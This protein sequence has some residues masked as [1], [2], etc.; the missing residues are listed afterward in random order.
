MTTRIRPRP[1]ASRWRVDFEVAVVGAGQAGLA[2]SHKLT[3]AGVA[4]VVL[5]R[6]RV[7][8]TWRGH[9]DSFCLVTP[10]WSVQ[11]P[12]YCYDGDD[13]DGFMPRDQ[14]VAYLQR[15]AARF[16]APVREGVEVTSLRP[17]DG[18]FIL[19]TSAGRLTARQVVVCTG[20]FQ[21][22]HRPAAAALPS[23]VLDVDVDDYRNPP[24]LPPG[25]VLIVGSGQSGCQIAEDLSLSAREV[26]MSCGRTSW[27]PRR[28]GEQDAFW[29]ML[30]TGFL[31]TPVSA[32]PSPAARLEGNR[33]ATGRGG[34]HD[35]HL[36]T[37]HRA[38]VTLLGHF[39]GMHGHRA[40]FAPD[41]AATIAWGDQQYARFAD[42]IRD[43]AV[44]RRMSPPHLPPPEPLGIDPPT[45]LDLRRFGAVVFASGFRPDYASWVD[46]PGAFDE[47]G[48]PIQHDGAS[49]LVEGL[50]FLGVHYLRKRKSSFLIGVG[51]D[52][53]IVAARIVA[54]LPP[55]ASHVPGSART[56]RVA[57]LA[58]EDHRH[59]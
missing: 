53:A 42:L 24:S 51:E 56:W 19:D 28:I 30:E 11:L 21:R 31:D 34:G 7:G 18:G 59:H 14:V 22:P 3:Q 2:V 46:C 32:L 45:E 15:Y 4:H 58:T 49:T 37:L 9:W 35:L 20:A 23:D 57:Q 33:Q 27:L 6:A 40:Q 54:K 55:P 38:G 1:W 43:L 41:L 44:E 13:P 52:A 47:L 36:R 17:T 16:E 10:N 50:Y 8:Q 39:R 48:F 12:D 5:E 26:F 25:P 29:W